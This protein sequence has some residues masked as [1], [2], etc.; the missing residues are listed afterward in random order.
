MQRGLSRALIASVMGVGLAFGF[1]GTAH[2]DEFPNSTPVV[3]IVTE[4]NP[5]AVS[6]VT[7]PVNSGSRRWSPSAYIRAWEN[8]N[9][10]RM[11][12]WERNALAR[13]CIGV[14][15]VNLERGNGNPPLGMSFN[16]FEQA[17]AVMQAFEWA[18]QGNPS[19]HEYRQRIAADPLLR[20]VRN[21][22]QYFPNGYS[23]AAITPVMFSKRFY[24]GGYNGGEDKYIPSRRTGQV[25]MS[26]YRYGAKPGY[27]NFDYGWFDPRTNN[28]W[29]ANRAEPGMEIY[30]STL[31]YYSRGLMDFDGQVFSIAFGLK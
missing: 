20:Q 15:V 22:P 1:A 18:L 3:D 31:N 11:H 14:S 24:M 12:S 13:G 7:S 29:H 25:D 19:V 27:V 21:V 2:A 10:R 17:R 30:Q 9:G 23:A 5:D 8:A 16:T 26:Y 6:P 4:G 28:W